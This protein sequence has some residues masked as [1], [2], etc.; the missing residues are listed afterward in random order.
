[1]MNWCKRIIKNEPDDGCMKGRPHQY[2]DEGLSIAYKKI[3]RT[4]DDLR[5][6]IKMPKISGMDFLSGRCI[7]ENFNIL[8][9]GLRY[10]LPLTK[11]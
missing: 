6:D 11:P 3:A 5:L 1:M 8:T 10:S 7:L 4:R 9:Y 2:V